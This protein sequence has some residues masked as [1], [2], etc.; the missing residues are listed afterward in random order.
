MIKKIIQFIN[1]FRYTFDM[2]EFTD[3]DIEKH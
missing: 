1:R 3:E 2:P